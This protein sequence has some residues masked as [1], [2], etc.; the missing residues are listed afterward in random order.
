MSNNNSTAPIRMQ[1]I[2]IS[3]VEAA[4]IIRKALKVKYPGV[5]FSVRAS[6]F[7][8]GSAV[9]IRFEAELSSRE[10]ESFAKGLVGCCGFD[11]SDDSTYYNTSDMTMTENGPVVYNYGGWVNA[12]RDRG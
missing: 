10:V 6:A 9:D 5:K 12:S 3:H 7:S 4:K 2:S 8:M 1:T 11:G